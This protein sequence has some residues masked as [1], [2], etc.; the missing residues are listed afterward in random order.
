MVFISSAR[1]QTKAGVLAPVALLAVFLMLSACRTSA[2]PLP[3]PAGIDRRSLPPPDT[4]LKIPGLSPCTPSPDATLHLDCHQPVTIIVHGCR[5]SAARFRSLAQ[6]FAFHGQQAVCFS[7]ND[8]DSLMKSSTELINALNSLSTKMH[9]R[10]ITV[11]GH[12]QGGLISRKAL[13]KER[14]DPLSGGNAPQ[15]LITISAPYAGIAAAGHCASPAARWMSLGLVIPICRLISGDKWYEI[16]RPSPFIQEPGELIPT[17]AVHLKIVTDE[18]GSCRR[19]DDNG[20]CVADDFV[21]SLAEQYFEPV[22]APACVEN[23]EVAAGHAEIV[24]DD[25]TAPEK[26]IRLLQQ[27][28]IMHQTPPA[29]R[30]ELAT[31]L[32]RLYVQATAS[33]HSSTGCPRSLNRAVGPDVGARSHLDRGPKAR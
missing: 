3:E 10:R 29:R 24:G 12:S 2:P 4:S 6:V 18:A 16:T 7:Y 9:N 32:S 22:D 1:L 27:K 25:N 31:L 21:F 19:Y 33:E 15:R 14:K 11:I 30:D 20:M 23:I 26:L 5:G 28:G 13:I 8:R 17:V